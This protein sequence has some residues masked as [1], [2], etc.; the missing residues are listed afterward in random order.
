[1]KLEQLRYFVK[2]VEC[3]SF[4]QAARELYLTQPALTKSIQALEDELH[5]VLLH[6]SKSGTYPT[7]YGLRVYNDCKGILT[8]LEEKIASWQSFTAEREKI[9]GIVHLA[10]IP[11]LCNLVLEHIIEGIAATYPEIEIMLHDIS[12]ST[13]PDELLRGRFNIGITS[14]ADDEKEEQKR[15]YRAMHFQAQPLLSDT[16]NIYISA[17]H[18]FAKKPALSEADCKALRVITYSS[19]QPIKFTPVF[20]NFKDIQYLNS[21][22]NILQMV[23]DNKGATVLMR[24]AMRNNWYVK[25]GLICAK[26]LQDQTIT[27]NKHV[28]LWADDSI[29]STAERA[30][31]GYIQKN[32]T[33][34]YEEDMQI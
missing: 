7:E 19:N 2:V 17:K 9:A 29:L 28:L 18:P 10:A 31:V 15:H 1:M 8:N 12:M 33:R 23:A 3:H 24:R 20:A 26:E 6:R 30:V 22:G 16:Y 14:V 21:I 25:N 13:F 34:L 32:Y 11:V 27:P 5:V 4:N